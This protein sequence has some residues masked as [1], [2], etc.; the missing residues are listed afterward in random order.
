MKYS[1]TQE[2]MLKRKLD[3]TLELLHGVSVEFPDTKRVIDEHLEK[4]VSKKIY[5]LEM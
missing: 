4:S 2:K 5:Q 1:C 3:I